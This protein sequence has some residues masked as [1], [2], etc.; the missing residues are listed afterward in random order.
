MLWFRS[1]FLQESVKF[2]T[3]AELIRKHLCGNHECH[4]DDFI[5]EKHYE[6]ISLKII[7]NQYITLWITV[8]K[9]PLERIPTVSSL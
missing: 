8:E 6:Q 1:N 5:I 2:C 3:H 7:Q 4:D 9:T